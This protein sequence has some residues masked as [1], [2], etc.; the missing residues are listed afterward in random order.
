MSCSHRYAVEGG[1]WEEV[2][3]Y[4]APVPLLISV[5]GEMDTANINSIEMTLTPH[6]EVALARF[7]M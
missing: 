7:L 2:G 4:D 6:H 1:E 5:C 3:K